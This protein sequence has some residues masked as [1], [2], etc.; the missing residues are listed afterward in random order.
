MH[1]AKKRRT[2]RVTSTREK[3]LQ[4][5]QERQQQQQNAEGGDDEDVWET[6]DSATTASN[7]SQS[8]QI[9][10]VKTCG[11]LVSAQVALCNITT[12]LQ[13]M[14]THKCV[15]TECV[16]K[17]TLIDLSAEE[18]APFVEL[19]RQRD[20]GGVAV[21]DDDNGGFELRLTPFMGIEDVH[22]LCQVFTADIPNGL[23]LTRE[24]RGA[25]TVHEDSLKGCYHGVEKDL[26]AL[27]AAGEVEHF[28]DDAC[29][30]SRKCRVFVPAR[31]GLQA[32]DE[33][34]KLWNDVAV[35]A[36][37]GLRKELLQRGIRSS[38]HYKNMDALRKQRNEEE[39]VK[40]KPVKR[41]KKKK[42]LDPYLNALNVQMEEEERVK[43][44]LSQNKTRGIDGGNQCANN[45]QA[46]FEAT[47]VSEQL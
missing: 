1:N 20:R 42:A 35:P 31:R 41:G 29:S 39:R 28:T 14:N 45:V 11:T 13:R 26:D 6:E 21:E 40:S 16:L 38:E 12:M 18:N 47:V 34:R 5:K 4:K 36:G 17:E 15:S 22:S 9:K 46:Q 43:A 19:M 8:S 2:I 10:V 32:S 37:E 25:F 23:A 3:R 33:C 27:I 7:K 24:G 44:V 30:N